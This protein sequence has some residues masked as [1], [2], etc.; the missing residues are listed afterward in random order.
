MPIK[1]CVW[2]LLLDVVCSIVRDF[3][4]N[5]EAASFSPSAHI[6]LQQKSGGVPLLPHPAAH[7]WLLIPIKC[8]KI[9]C[10]TK[11]PCYPACTDG[12]PTPNLLEKTKE[13]SNRKRKTE[14]KCTSPPAPPPPCGAERGACSKCASQPLSQRDHICTM[15]TFTSRPYGLYLFSFYKL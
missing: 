5:T 2:W 9:F 11:A 12:L 1:R 14:E 13:D 6:S 8:R 3:Q 15:V 7:M 4:K 10:Q